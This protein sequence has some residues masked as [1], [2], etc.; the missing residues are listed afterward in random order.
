MNVADAEK[1]AGN[2]NWWKIQEAC[3]VAVHN[4]R[5][6]ILDT[7]NQ[8]DL[9]NYLTLVRNLLNY[10]ESFH[11]IG[12]ALWT[13]STYSKSKLYNPQMLE[14]I[15]AVTLQSLSREKSIVLKI[16]AVR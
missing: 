16:S 7:E 9:L 13:L 4:Y 10:H 3:M 14:E 12:R 15:L 1:S 11:L 8:F 6:M 2:P 5:V